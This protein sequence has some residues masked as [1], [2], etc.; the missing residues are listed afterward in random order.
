MKAYRQLL[1]EREAY[2]MERALDY[3]HHRRPYAWV[4]YMK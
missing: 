1:F 4:R 2:D 3:R